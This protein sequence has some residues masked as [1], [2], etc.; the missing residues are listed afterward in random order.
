MPVDA[1]A[2]LLR[3]LTRPAL[4]TRQLPRHSAI[5]TRAMSIRHVENATQLDGILSQSKDKLS[6][7]V[8]AWEFIPVRAEWAF[9]SLTSML[10]GRRFIQGVDK[11]GG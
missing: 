6:V 9:R 11:L 1:V 4:V 2:M 7:S 5:L 3:T 8:S 10:L